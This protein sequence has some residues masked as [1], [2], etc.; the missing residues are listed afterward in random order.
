M[1]QDFN[2]GFQDVSRSRDADFFLQ[3]LDSAD[4]L[5]TMQSCK[6]RML[7]MHPIAEGAHVLDVG[8]GIGHELQRL[9]SRVGQ[10][11]RLVG[12]DKSDGMVE[13]ARRRAVASG[14]SI[15][16]LTVDAHELPFADETFDCC[17]TERVLMYT[18]DP[19][20]ILAE[21]TRVLR[22]GGGLVLFEFD[23]DGMMLSASDRDLARRVQQELYR[24][25]P[26]GSIGS[27]LPYHLQ[28][29]GLTEVH[30]VPHVITTPY[31]MYQRIAR[32]TLEQAQAAGVFT[33]AELD[34]WW[35]EL[36]R[37]SQEGYFLVAF[38][39]FIVSGRKT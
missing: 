4:A 39:G 36:E 24:S 25:V 12:I 37:A 10:R 6:R 19:A 18:Q 1:S 35:A 14:H 22:P 3:F 21:M 34:A 30:A 26:S 27:R 2:R 9:A 7:E 16:Y 29:L 32:G 5:E 8:C 33:A 15:E 13:E 28:R 17:R 31:W 23:Y 11:G 38:S 20:R